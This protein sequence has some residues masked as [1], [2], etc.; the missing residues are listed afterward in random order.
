MIQTK[1]Q[2]HML[3]LNKESCVFLDALNAVFA[4]PKKPMYVFVRL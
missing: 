2:G 1:Q 4:L 3:M